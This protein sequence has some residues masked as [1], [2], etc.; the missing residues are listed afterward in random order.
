M[1]YCSLADLKQAIPEENLIQLTDDAAL[2]VIDEVKINAAIKGAEELVE[3]YLRGRYELPFQNV[4]P[5]IKQIVTDI[6]L[7]NLYNRRFELN[8]PEHMK[9]RYKNAIKILEHIN[10]GL[11]RLGVESEKGPGSGYYKTN[12]TKEDRIFKNIT[13]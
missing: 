8:M 13:F 5:L 1:R 12:K 6:A 11:I 4:P 9:E 7:Y 10:K 2:G 3:A